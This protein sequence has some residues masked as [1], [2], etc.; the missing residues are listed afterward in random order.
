VRKRYDEREVFVLILKK[1]DKRKD[2][3]K[4]MGMDPPL[5]AG[6]RGIRY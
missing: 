4:K 6:A 5:R 2:R 3:Y 1:W